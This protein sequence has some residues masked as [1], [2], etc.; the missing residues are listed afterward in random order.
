ME[1]LGYHWTDFHNILLLVTFRKSVE[2]FQM[3]LTSDKNDGYFKGRTL[4]IFENILFTISKNV[5]FSDKFV[6]GIQLTFE[7][8][9]L[10]NWTSFKIDKAN[11]IIARHCIDG[12]IVRRMC[13]TFSITKARNSHFE[14]L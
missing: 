13:C 10:E 6:E 5:N 1:H 9:F 8:H 12:N 11:P 4:H 14:Y 2:E 7:V 3:S